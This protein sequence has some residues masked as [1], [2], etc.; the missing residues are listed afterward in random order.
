MRAY[1]QHAQRK[2][3]G[4]ILGFWSVRETRDTDVSLPVAGN[5]SG[6]KVC[7]AEMG[8]AGKAEKVHGQEKFNATR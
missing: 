7:I 6:R 5:R 1:I 3:L 2:R 8:S 4:Q